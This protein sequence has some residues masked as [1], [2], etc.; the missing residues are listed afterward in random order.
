MIK[1]NIETAQAL[2]DLISQIEDTKQILYALRD[3][4]NSIKPEELQDV[5]NHLAGVNVSGLVNLQQEI[6]NNP[7]T[8][9]KTH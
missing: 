8:A 9:D 2:S 5:I 3:R 4:S 1:L 7:S 6:S